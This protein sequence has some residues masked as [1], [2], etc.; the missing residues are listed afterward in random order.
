[1]K[2]L[3]RFFNVML[4][5]LV[6]LGMVVMSKTTNINAEE[7]WSLTYDL[8]YD[9]DTNSYSFKNVK[10]NTNG[11]TVGNIVISFPESFVVADSAPTTWTKVTKDTATTVK[12]FQTANCSSEDIKTYLEG[13]TL[14]ATAVTDASKIKVAIDASQYA[15]VPY[16]H[17]DGTTH[18]YRFV[19]MTDNIGNVSWGDAYNE[20]ANSTYLGYKG[21]LATLTS[22]AED[23]FVYNSIATKS[24]FLGGTR[25]LNLDGSKI[26]DRQ[27]ITN[28]SN[29]AEPANITIDPIETCDKWYWACGPE[30]GTVFSTTP[31]RP[32]QLVD[33]EDMF[34]S[35]E[36]NNSGGH[37]GFL[38]F[39]YN[40][41]VWNDCR[42][43]GSYT[44]DTTPGTKIAGYYAE[45][46]GYTNE[47]PAAN[48][49]NY[50]SGEANAAISY[51]K[52]SAQDFT[53]KIGDGAL[54]DTTALTNGKVPTTDDNGNAL[55][56][57]P[58]PDSLK[59]L[60][61]KIAAGQRGEFPLVYKTPDGTTL[62][63]N[64][65]LIGDT[66]TAATNTYNPVDGTL[67]SSDII[68]LNNVTAKDPEGN[69]YD[70]S[71]LKVDQDQLNKINEAI[72]NKTYGDYE[73]TYYTPDGTKVTSIVSLKPDTIVAT[74]PSPVVKPGSGPYTGE[75][76][77][78]IAGITVTD[79]DGNPVD[80]S[81]VTVNKAQLDAF[82]AAVA[83]GKAGKYAVTFYA[84]D[85][86]PCVVYF[87]VES[88]VK[89]SDT[90]ST[91][92]FTVMLLVSGLMLI[93]L[94]KVKE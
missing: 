48:G 49:S 57:L 63:I 52:A 23:N 44:D 3:K 7:N 27:T 42:Y 89:T 47:N 24:G 4:S 38:Q 20:A 28:V 54:T 71:D 5:I 65:T 79:K 80:S 2:T 22:K 91:T 83:A 81:K 56:I 41:N 94:K 1:M 87:T 69:P 60:N 86:T 36:P 68:K 88:T 85:G 45:F 73:I 10:V 6:V 84:P 15:T 61:E 75:K 34:S 21:Y 70:S 29:T 14:T 19:P 67:T 66:I 35:G 58:D 46:G 64:V 32:L 62:T 31:K 17:A 30:A 50:A 26:S 92:L 72:K 37:E 77:Q 9:K 12:A 51:A 39:A 82:N 53:Y 55:N 16:D 43:N 59:A 8:T 25:S 33:I 40:G 18:Y 76:L 93:K 74:N 78:E 11:E 13:I 90:T